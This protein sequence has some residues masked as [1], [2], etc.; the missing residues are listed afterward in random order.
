MV[1]SLFCSLVKVPLKSVAFQL[2]PGLLLFKHRVW[3]VRKHC[4]ST[5][6][7]RIYHESFTLKHLRSEP[8]ALKIIYSLLFF[9]SGFGPPVQALVILVFSFNYY[10]YMRNSFWNPTLYKFA[11]ISETTKHQDIFR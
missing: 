9:Y 8:A 3:V 4:T 10:K 7:V 5:F 1:L 6:L 2:Y 11:K